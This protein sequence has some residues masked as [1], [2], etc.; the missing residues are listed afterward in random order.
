M[1][2]VSGEPEVSVW[3]SIRTSSSEIIRNVVSWK[4]LDNVRGWELLLTYCVILAQ[5]SWNQKMTLANGYYSATELQ[6]VSIMKSTVLQRWYEGFHIYLHAQL[7]ENKGGNF[8][9]RTRSLLLCMFNWL[10]C[11]F[12][13]NAIEFATKSIALQLHHRLEPEVFLAFVKNHR[14][15]NIL[16]YGSVGSVPYIMYLYQFNIDSLLRNLLAPSSVSK[17]KQQI[18]PNSS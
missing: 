5:R 14:A 4:F 2:S 16:C 9:F 8:H 1:L 3:E 12:V 15:G 18:S 13:V 7:V 17:W 10:W 6:A 11:S